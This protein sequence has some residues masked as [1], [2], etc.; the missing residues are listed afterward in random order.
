MNA[1][2]LKMAKDDSLGI[3]YL[4]I[5]KM[6][7]TILLFSA[8][9]SMLLLFSC[10]KSINDSPVQDK[11]D[12]SVSNQSSGADVSSTEEIV[13]YD[14]TLFVPCGNG[15]AGED[16]AL[17]GSLKILENI[18]YNDH[19]FTFNYHVIT[20]GITGVGLSTGEK[21]QASG[22]NKGTITG[23]FGEEGQYS[24]VFIQQLRI[25]GQNSVF[26]VTYKTKIT[27]TPDGKITTSIDDETID[28]IM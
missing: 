24:R 20:Q 10:K 2:I 8:I 14:Q 28:C 13:P 15:G 6:K 17:T 12:A 11:V 16:V 9:L 1:Q 5:K 25:I 3:L 26:K 4:A 21:F 23:E 22:G 7:S 27:I 19:G 18:V